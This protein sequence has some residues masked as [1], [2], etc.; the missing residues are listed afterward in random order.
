MN[1]TTDELPASLRLQQSVAYHFSATTKY[2]A[3]TTIGT[4]TPEPDS[5]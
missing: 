4:T 2:H 1:S 3:Y 5:L